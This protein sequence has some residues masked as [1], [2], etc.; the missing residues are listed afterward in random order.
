MSIT[1]VDE[2]K[3][4]I[5]YEGCGA[6]HLTSCTTFAYFSHDHKLTSPKEDTLVR[7]R[8]E[9]AGDHAFHTRRTPPWGRFFS[10][11]M[12]VEAHWACLFVELT[13][14]HPATQK[15]AAGCSGLPWSLKNGMP[16]LLPGQD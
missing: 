8:K 12:P 4:E 1:S 7:I 9:G 6:G 3:Y 15:E 10:S 2:I 5:K 11:F 13:A 16:P 14:A